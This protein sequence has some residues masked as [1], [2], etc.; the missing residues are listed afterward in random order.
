[1]HECIVKTY[2]SIWHR[3]S[4]MH[5]KSLQCVICA[6]GKLEIST[7]KPAFLFVFFILFY[8]NMRY[9]DTLGLLC[10]TVICLFFYSFF[11]F[12]YS[13]HTQF[14]V[15]TSHISFPHMH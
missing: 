6:Q 2:I 4:S 7:V 13:V 3:A 15:Y 14:F 9:D 1:M 8:M 11:S 5:S 10:S 12:K